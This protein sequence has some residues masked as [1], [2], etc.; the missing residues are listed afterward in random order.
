MRLILLPSLFCSP[1]ISQ[2]LQ[3]FEQEFINIV[4]KVQA[5]VVKLEISYQS[6]TVQR[7]SSGIILD[8]KG[9]L[10]TVASAVRGGQS[11]VAYLQTGMKLPC[12]LVG[13]DAFTNL[14]VLK[15]EELP[16][17]IV[18]DLIPRNLEDL[19]VG[20][21]LI[22]VGNPYGLHNSVATGIVSGLDRCVW[23]NG[24]SRP[25]TG[26][27][28]TTAPINP[29]DDGGLVVDSS[30]RFVGMIFCTL[31]RNT[32]ITN[33]TD[34]FFD[35]FSLIQEFKANSIPPQI[36]MDRIEQLARHIQEIPKTPPSLVPSGN[37]VIP[38]GINFILPS[39][40]IYWV[41][42]QLIQHGKISRG[43]VGIKV[44]DSEDTQ[45]VVIIQVE[46]NSPAAKSGLQAG[47][48][49]IALG[50]RSI[51]NSLS[52]LHQASYLLENQPVQITYCRGSETLTT[53][54]TPTE[55]QEK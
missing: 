4:Q 40:T 39:P 25:L 8:T 12:Y 49:L 17:N 38:Q 19:K 21:F 51:T 36:F 54:L 28:Q 45:G 53:T 23:M 42:N 14:A 44:K 3:N 16:P 15:L 52:L 11:V 46:P 34:F 9:H 31:N 32:Y 37:L 55:F 30:G 27:I 18:P 10:V 20:A 2:S 26:L 50:E 13:S 35:L 29:G 5:C 7:A 1:L 47:D 48:R 33:H 6:R 24:R 41:A 43:W 22:T